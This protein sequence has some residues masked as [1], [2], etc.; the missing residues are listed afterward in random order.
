MNLFD[1]LRSLLSWARVGEQG[2]W[3]YFENSITGERRAYRIGALYGPKNDHWLAGGS[4]ESPRPRPPRGG[5][6]A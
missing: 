4:W 2:A 5:S 1:K 6:A 3:A